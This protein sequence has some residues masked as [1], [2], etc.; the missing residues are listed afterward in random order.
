MLNHHQLSRSIKIWKYLIAR[1][2]F[3]LIQR[4]HGI[5]ASDGTNGGSLFD[6]IIEQNEVDS[7]FKKTEENYYLIC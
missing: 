6:S 4:K 7:G 2:I 3:Q 5:E 1:I